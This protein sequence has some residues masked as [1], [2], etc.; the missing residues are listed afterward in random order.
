MLA[1]ICSHEEFPGGHCPQAA[2]PRESSLLTVLSRKKIFCTNGSF[3]QTNLLP[4]SELCKCLFE[5][6]I[7]CT[8]ESFAQSDLLTFDILSCLPGPTAVLYLLC[9]NSLLQFSADT[10]AESEFKIEHAKD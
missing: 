4:K 1:S 2:S 6:Y 8:S 5:Q 3:A 9:L 10:D 7:F